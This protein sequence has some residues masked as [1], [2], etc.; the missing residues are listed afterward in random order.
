MSDKPKVFVTRLVQKEIMDV[1]SEK[2]IMDIWAQKEP[3]P[4]EKLLDKVRSVNG[5][6]CQTTDRLDTNFFNAAKELK[7]VAVVGTGTDNIDLETASKRGIVVGNTPGVTAKSTAD[8]TLGLLLS[9][10]R[11]IP[12]SQKWLREG[13]WKHDLA[14][15]GWLGPEVQGSTLGLIGIGKIG[16]E[17]AK[18]AKGFDMKILYFSRTR[19]VELEE[20]LNLIWT[21]SLDDLLKQSD[22]ISLHVPLTKETKYIISK[23]EL[24]KM[25]PTAI[26]INTSRGPVVNQKDLYEALKEKKISA[27]GLDVLEIE[28]IPLSDSILSL[29]NV[30]LTP[31]LGTATHKTR[32]IMAKMAL[33]NLLAGLSNKKLPFPVN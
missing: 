16:T 14:P 29:D 19:K 10:A 6:Y 33:E 17:V 21:N 31:H 18:R 13:N 25:K 11:N 30:V 27:A 22:F 1:I 23:K 9:T 24:D 5:I 2:S 20:S 15:M 3:I 12:N 7:V 4:Y 32:A 8:M 28:P 26:L